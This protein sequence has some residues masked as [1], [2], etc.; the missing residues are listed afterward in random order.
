MPRF[1]SALLQAYSVLEETSPA[2]ARDS[3]EEILAEFNKLTVYTEV[4]RTYLDYLKIMVESLE[5]NDN[6]SRD[7]WRLGLILDVLRN[8][9]DVVEKLEESKKEVEKIMNKIGSEL[10]NACSDCKALENLRDALQSWEEWKLLNLCK[11]KAEIKSINKLLREKLLSYGSKDK[12][13]I[14]PFQRDTHQRKG[15]ANSAT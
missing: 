1:P 2:I 15:K 12:K 8:V 7:A 4:L 6:A 14:L 13:G 5:A 3:L 9:K 11:L 10:G